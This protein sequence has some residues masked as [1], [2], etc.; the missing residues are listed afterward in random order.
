[1]NLPDLDVSCPKRDVDPVLTRR[2]ALRT[3]SE[4]VPNDAERI[5]VRYVKFFYSSRVGLTYRTHRM[6]RANL[7]DIAPISFISH[8]PVIYRA[9]INHQTDN[10]MR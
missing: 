1:M 9:R 3:A 6:Y 7:F 2:Q 5:W 4:H 10:D 8:R